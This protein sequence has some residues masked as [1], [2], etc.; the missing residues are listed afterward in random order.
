MAE[1]IKIEFYK[2]SSTVSVDF[3]KEEDRNICIGGQDD[4]YLYV[5][6]DSG[7]VM[8]KKVA[9]L[10]NIR[11]TI[12][13]ISRIICP[14]IYVLLST[15]LNAY[16]GTTLQ[17]VDFYKLSG[18]SCNI[19]LFHDLM[20]EFVPGR[21]IRRKKK[22]LSEEGRTE[23]LKIACLEGSIRY[24]MAKEFNQ[25]K[26]EIEMAPPKMLYKIY[27]DRGDDEEQL[28]LSS[29]AS[30]LLRNFLSGRRIHFIVR[31]SYG[32]QKNS[33]FY[34]FELDKNKRMDI[35]LAD[36]KLQ[37]S[38]DTYWAGEEVERHI[39]TPLHD[40]TLHSKAEN[41]QCIFLLPAKNGYGFRIYQVRI[42]YGENGETKYSLVRKQLNEAS[43]G[44]YQSF[45][46]MASF[47]D[48]KR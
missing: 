34:D 38:N 48:G 14:D 19:T 33:V 29:E 28:V 12:K 7:S 43:A 46:Q 4:Y 36:L 39:I 10:G 18:Q 17:K 3:D 2:S 5:R 32:Q 25:I 20:K 22:S 27:E 11:I 1:A 24:L 9:P 37:L 45:E 30:H 26:P 31:D 44:E 6:K 15:L 41:E 16:E 47:F 21:I 23:E 8:E 40:I 42:S 13:E 35:S